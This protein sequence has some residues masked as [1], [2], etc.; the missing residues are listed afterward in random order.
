MSSPSISRRGFRNFRGTDRQ[1]REAERLARE[2]AAE[3]GQPVR[4]AIRLA[5]YCGPGS[6][7]DRGAACVELW[8]GS[9]YGS[10]YV[11]AGA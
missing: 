11:E 4:V 10:V 5:T 9:H 8:S 7:G 3:T 2:W 6:A 1:K